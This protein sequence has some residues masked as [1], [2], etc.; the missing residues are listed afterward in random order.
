MRTVIEIIVVNATLTNDNADM[1]GCTA[2]C[3]LSDNKKV[4]L[5]RTWQRPRLMEMPIAMVAL[6]ESQT[7]EKGSVSVI[8]VDRPTIQGARMQS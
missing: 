7:S 3:D 4:K 1:H 8:L 5:Y 6:K 2:P